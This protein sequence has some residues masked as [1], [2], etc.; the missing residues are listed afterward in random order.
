MIYL[1]PISARM[2]N[3]GSGWYHPEAPH[4]TIFNIQRPF[5][6]LSVGPMILGPESLKDYRRWV[7]RKLLTSH[8]VIQEFTHMLDVLI[9]EGDIILQCSCIPPKLCHGQIIR[10]ALM[11]ASRFGIEEWHNQ[12]KIAAANNYAKTR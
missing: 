11:W 6:H 1:L 8:A 3:N 4:A 7:F 12:L 9:Q 5:A 2:Q 10:D